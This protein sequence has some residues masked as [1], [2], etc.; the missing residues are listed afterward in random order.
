MYKNMK[1]FYSEQ[2]IFHRMLSLTQMWKVMKLFTILIFALSI[3]LSA[4]SNAQDVT[5]K[6]SHITLKKAFRQIEKQTGYSFFVNHQL[7]KEATPVSLSLKKAT[8]DEA[9][10]ACLR[11]Q[12]LTYSI[13]DKTVILKSRE[14]VSMTPP[15]KLLP[16]HEI[17]GKV[18]DSTTGEPLVGV[19]IKV[20]G[21]GTGTVTDAE[22]KFSLKVESQAVLV[23]SYL[24]YASKEISAA[25]KQ[26]I[27][28]SLNTS[29]TGLTQMLVVGHGPRKKQELTG[30]IR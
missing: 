3:Q 18:V 28:N 11:N 25:G 24:G 29:A 10:Q 13:I 21:S 16:Q 26:S 23:V 20:K 27:T 19:S 15:I 17:T 1:I 9:L 8:I 30:S 5:L 14:I 6:A 2:H 12:P 4:K 22:G 7:L